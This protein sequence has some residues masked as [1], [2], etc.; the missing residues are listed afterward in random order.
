MKTTFLLILIC[1]L[2][3]EAQEPSALDAT[4]KT[5]HFEIH[6]SK[7][8]RTVDQVRQ[9]VESGM[10]LASDFLRR[11]F[12]RK[13]DVFVFPDRKL[14]DEQWQKAWNLPAF[15]SECWMVGSGVESRLDLLSPAVWDLQACEHDP[16]DSAELRLL[17]YHELIH[18]L[19]SDYNRSPS[20]EE[21]NNI[22]WFVEGLADH[23]PKNGTVD[24]VQK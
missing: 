20:F 1:L 24:L 16:Q 7:N 10:D 19:H 13:I 12:K 5:E 21:V 14:L 8:D 15:K 2:L 23:T 22:G 17:V 3:S 9:Y 11:E 18:I 4:T 6:Y